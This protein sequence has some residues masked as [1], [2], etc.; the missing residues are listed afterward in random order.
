M[1]FR[2]ALR[3]IRRGAGE[4]QPAQRVGAEL[5]KHLIRINDVAERFGHFFAMLV[6][7][8][9]QAHAVFERDTVIHQHADR[10]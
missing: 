2:H 9:I 3:H 1:I 5:V 7:D 10:M 4:K 6:N 8:V